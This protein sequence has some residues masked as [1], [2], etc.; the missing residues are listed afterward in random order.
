VA[1]L[2][3]LAGAGHPSA[4]AG[5][6]IYIYT[7]NTDMT[8]T[9]LYTSDGDFLIGTLTLDSARPRHT[10]SDFVLSLSLSLAL[11]CPSRVRSTF[12]PSSASLK[13]SPARLPSSRG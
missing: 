10:L 7:A 2:R 6:A 5:M 9:A 1:G 12:R 8:N 11:Q 3:T 4:K 13:L